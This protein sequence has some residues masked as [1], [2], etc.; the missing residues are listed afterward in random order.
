M[1]Y[2][3]PFAPH[4]ARAWFDTG[5]GWTP[6]DWAAPSV[7]TA[8][9]AWIRRI[10]Q[11]TAPAD[12]VAGTDWESWLESFD[13]AP[14][15]KPEPLALPEGLDLAHPHDLRWVEYL[16]TRPGRRR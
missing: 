15:D 4:T 10:E 11:A 8:T 12:P 13:E 5:L 1:T 7:E 16:A 3:F 9:E 14:S 2:R 6:V